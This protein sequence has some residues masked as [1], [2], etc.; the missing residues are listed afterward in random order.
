[1]RMRIV[2]AQAKGSDGSGWEA[3]EMASNSSPWS[4]IFSDGPMALPL[5]GGSQRIRSLF[6]LTTSA[7]FQVVR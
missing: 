5:H 4:A 7:A 2:P 3:P 1:M 6:L